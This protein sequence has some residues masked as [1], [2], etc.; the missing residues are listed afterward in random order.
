M[1]ANGS[2][3]FA[4]YGYA[5]LRKYIYWSTM[6]GVFSAYLRVQVPISIRLFDGIMLTN[7][8]LM[9]LLVNFARIPTW[10]VCL[11]GYLALSGGIG[12][13]NGTDTMTQVSKEL[14]GIS[15]SVTYF[16]YFFKMIG[17]NFERAFLTYASIAFWFTVIALPIWVG[18]CLY[19]QKYAR[20]RGLTAEPGAFC[21]I[22][23]PAYY[24][25]VYSYFRSRK[26]GGKVAIFTLAVVLS[27]STLGYL[28]V[29]LGAMLLLSG[30][31]KYFLA[32][33]IVVGGLLAL[34]YTFSTDFRLRAD[35]T[36]LA[37]ATQDVSR[38]NLSTYASFSNLFVTEQV[39]KESPVI[40]KGL[41]SHP[42][43]HARFIGD[44]PGIETFAGTPAEEL[45]ATEAAS[46]ALRSLSELGIAGFSAVLIFIFYFRV[47]GAGTRAAV[48]NAILVNFVFKLVRDGNYF[49]P[50]QFFFVFIYMLNYRQYKLEKLSG[51]RRVSTTSP[52]WSELPR[53][54]SS[55]RRSFR[56]L[57][58]RFW[59]RV[60]PHERGYLQAGRK[61]ALNGIQ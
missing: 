55:P 19:L 26:G 34:A 30:R 49:P 58:A 44:V 35:D 51:A 29:A 9:F 3:A 57:F 28:G 43:S 27:S 15:I 1:P 41:G 6:I 48:S 56:R 5:S 21:E 61:G 54:A 36:L 37:A 16:Y 32:L 13:A 4:G 53:S 52:G 45:N 59:A 2:D 25:Y 50:E 22:V 12:I 46:L 60:R 17:N 40:G 39:L 20:L 38:A 11:I 47:G 24:W 23:L 33:P 18:A 7:L 31:V 10:I 42:I 14:L 8:A